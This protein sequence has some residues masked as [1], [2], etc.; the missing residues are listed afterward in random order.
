LQGNAD[1]RMPAS[2]AIQLAKQSG[3]RATY[4]EF[5]GDHLLLAKRAN[6]VQKVLIEWLSQQEASARGFSGT[7]ARNNPAVNPGAHRP[8]GR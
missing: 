3:H 7:A 1:E 5:V 2:L 8:A 4:R 6:E